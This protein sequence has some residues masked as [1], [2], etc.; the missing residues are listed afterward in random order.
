MKN[1]SVM[2]ASVIP[3]CGLFLAGA[4]LLDGGPFTKILEKILGLMR[5]AWDFG[6]GI[7]VALA[8]LVGLYYVIQG[9]TGSLSGSG[10]MTA[11][12]ILGVVGIVVAV[13]VVF[14]LLPE[15][16]QLLKDNQPAAPF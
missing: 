2:P 6:V 4:F 12:A 13:L 10:G 5:N 14:L 15:L 16:A 3:T 1:G 9:V 7:L 11:K 8:L